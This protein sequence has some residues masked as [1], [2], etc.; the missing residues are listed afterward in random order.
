M[1]NYVNWF[2]RF[3]RHKAIR[4]TTTIDAVVGWKADVKQEVK[5]ATRS[6]NAYIANADSIPPVLT[7]Q[8][9]MGL[10]HPEGK[11]KSSG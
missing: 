3:E 6:D 11:A 10:R 4:N 7:W 8:I 9:T 1:V 5:Y 2:W